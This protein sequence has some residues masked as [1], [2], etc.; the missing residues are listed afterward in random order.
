MFTIF[1][2]ISYISQAY[3]LNAVIQ[4]IFPQF[5]SWNII[6]VSLCGDHSLQA[7]ALRTIVG[8]TK[9]VSECDVI[10]RAMCCCC[11]NNHSSGHGLRLHG[12]CVCTVVLFTYEAHPSPCV[13]YFLHSWVALVS[14]RS[15]LRRP[16]CVVA[17]HAGAVSRSIHYGE[18]C[19]ADANHYTHPLVA[20]TVQAGEHLCARAEL[21]DIPLQ[22][23]RT[24]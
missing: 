5:S 11:S 3:A 12:W 2:G 22:R 7:F 9:Q 6:F 14:L 1:Y 24:A 16:T 4:V 18:L 10:V 19:R 23:V 13:L 20:A 15:F 17:S 8:R 21:A